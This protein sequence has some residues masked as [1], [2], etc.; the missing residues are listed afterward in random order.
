M[1]Y[2]DFNDSNIIVKATKPSSTNDITKNAFAADSESKLNIIGIIDFND[3]CYSCL[4]FEIGIGLAYMVKI[5]REGDRIEVGRHFL[6]G[7]NSILPL[8]DQEWDLLPVCVAGRCV[9]S[10]LAGLYSHSREPTNE[11]LLLDVDAAW[12][13]VELVSS[14]TTQDIVARWRAGSVV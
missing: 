3:M 14:M 7:Y 10:I 9:Q 2:G 1:L 11:Y 12:N 4:L 8:T 6:Q 5:Q 13:V